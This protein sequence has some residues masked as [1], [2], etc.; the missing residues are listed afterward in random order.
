MDQSVI[1]LLIGVLTLLLILSV[2]LL[3]IY[4]GGLLEDVKV[5]VGQT[6]LADVSVFYKFGN[7]SYTDILGCS[8]TFTEA[9]SIAPEC[10]CFGVYY[11]DPDKVIIQ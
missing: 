5:E 9:T 8:F 2:I 3:I 7:G 4:S 6:P 10:K 11:D 1:L